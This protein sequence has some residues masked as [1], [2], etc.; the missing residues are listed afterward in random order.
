VIVRLAGFA[1]S[2]Q[3]GAA[4]AT[5]LFLHRESDSTAQS[6]VALPGGSKRVAVGACWFS[7]AFAGATVGGVVVPWLVCAAVAP[8]NNATA[9]P[10]VRCR[11]DMMVLL[12]LSTL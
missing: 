1:V 3:V 8:I 6:M 10:M 2:V 4:P 12:F 9:R 11:L 5:M 7:L